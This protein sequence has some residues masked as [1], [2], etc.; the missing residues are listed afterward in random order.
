MIWLDTNLLVRY[1]VQ[2]HEEQA[3]AASSLEDQEGMV[4]LSAGLEIFDDLFS[5]A[6]VFLVD[7]TFE[8]FVVYKEKRPNPQKELFPFALVPK[9]HVFLERSALQCSVPADLA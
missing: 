7:P 6:L 3:K 4:Y 8:P 2:D 1:I 9:N 5:D